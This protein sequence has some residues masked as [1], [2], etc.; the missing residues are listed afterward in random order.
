MRTEVRL[1]DERIKLLTCRAL[2]IEI[3]INNRRNP[4]VAHVS[5]AWAVVLYMSL[6]RNSALL[7][8]L[9]YRVLPSSDAGGYDQD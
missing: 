4:P 8:I 2:Q 3:I 9:L 5:Y 7:A 6:G 1:E